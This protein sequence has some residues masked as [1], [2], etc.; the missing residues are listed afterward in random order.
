MTT[1]EEYARGFGEEPGYLDYGRVG[2]LSATVRA[3]AI[4]QYEILS[5]ARYG[6][7]ERMRTEDERVREAVSALTGFPAD[8]V[9]FQPNASSGLLHAAFGLTGGDVLLSLSEFPSLTYAA[10]RAARALRVITPTWLETDGG[11]VTPSRI[12]EQLTDSTSAVMVSLVD[13]RTGYLADID[14]IRQVIGDRLL[15]VDA[16]QGFGVVDAPWEVA[17]VVVSGGQKWMRAGWGTGFLALSERAID[18]LTPVFSGWTGSGP[19]QPWDEVLEPVRGA[20]AFSISNPDLVAEAR[21]AAALEEVDAVG[22]SAISSAISDNVERVLQL[23][24]EFAVPV[25]SSRSP[26]ERAGMIVLEPLPEQLTVLGASLHNHGVTASVRAT[27]ARIS[28][29]AGTTEET[30]DMLRAAFTSYASAA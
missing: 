29:H 20:G 23:A 21:F 27:N 30:L 1:V 17:D 22:V 11:R 24:D 18:H 19:Q 3:E 2:P 9:S 10:E 12:R 8:Q 16:I 5:K 4:G 14:G 28:V 13:S 25:S 6:T 15:I 7:I 26:A